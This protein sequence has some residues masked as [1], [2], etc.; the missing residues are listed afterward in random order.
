MRESGTLSSLKNPETIFAKQRE[1]LK[2]VR[3][4]ERYRLRV[5]E[6]V[7][8]VTDPDI[9]ERIEKYKG[10]NREDL[11]KGNQKMQLLRLERQARYKAMIKD[12]EK[13]AKEIKRDENKINFEQLM[14]NIRKDEFDKSLALMKKI[15]YGEP[16]LIKQ[17]YL[18]ALK[19]VL[20]HELEASQVAK[21]YHSGK[22]DP[23]MMSLMDKK[24]KK[25]DKL[26]KRSK[27]TDR[28]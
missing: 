10:R 26:G 11:E 19:D 22:F 12:I 5:T 4:Q 8:K 24:S 9:V 20:D 23:F 2:S 6:D 15:E 16:L 21:N 7:P 1:Y 17:L 25:Q 14:Q 28:V 3:N 27:T 18:Y 13:I